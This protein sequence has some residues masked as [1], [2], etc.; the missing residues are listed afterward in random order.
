MEKTPE[1][2]H[3]GIFAFDIEVN[4]GCVYSIKVN[5]SY[6]LSY[7]RVEIVSLIQEIYEDDQE[8]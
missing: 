7:H 8:E 1:K 3:L 2:F 4:L 6:F 5:D